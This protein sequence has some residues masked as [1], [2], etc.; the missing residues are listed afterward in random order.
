MKMT[1][2][3]KHLWLD[4]DRGLK[5]YLRLKDKGMPSGGFKEGENYGNMRNRTQ[6]GQIIWI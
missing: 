1:E 2:Y 3:E 5:P 4:G 6:T